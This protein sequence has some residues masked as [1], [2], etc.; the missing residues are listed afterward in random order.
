M[1][2]E[3]NIFIVRETGT[4]VEEFKKKCSREEAKKRV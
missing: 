4:G 3:A 1:V 2:N